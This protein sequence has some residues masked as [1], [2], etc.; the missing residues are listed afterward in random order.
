[1]RSCQV[2][3]VSDVHLWWK[4]SIFKSGIDLKWYLKQDDKLDI[5][6]LMN[7]LRNQIFPNYLL[8][9]IMNR[10]FSH[11]SFKKKC[12]NIFSFIKFV[13]FYEKFLLLLSRYIIIFII[14]YMLLSFW[15]FQN[16]LLTFLLDSI[17]HKLVYTLYINYIM[18]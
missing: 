3:S 12:W 14:I 11:D 17:F 13:I 15:L 2:L 1:M 8:G 7:Y 6:S 5:S 4:V 9:Y 16:I 10:K 18:L